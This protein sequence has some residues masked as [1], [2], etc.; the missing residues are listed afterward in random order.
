MYLIFFIGFLIL[1]A[2]H[3]IKQAPEAM[4]LLNEAQ[5]MSFNGP[6]LSQR[7]S[8][9]MEQELGLPW[10]DWNPEI[11]ETSNFVPPSV[12]IQYLRRYF[13]PLIME[14]AGDQV[15]I[16]DMTLGL[17]SSPPEQGQIYQTVISLKPP[18]LRLPP[19]ILR[20]RIGI[21]S[22]LSTAEAIKTGTT[23]DTV[24][25][26]E[27]FAPHRVR[28][29]FQSKLGTE[30][31][32]PF[33][34]DHKWTVEWSDDRLTVYER[35]KLIAPH[36]IAEVALAASEFFDLLKSG[37]DAVDREMKKFIDSAVG[38]AR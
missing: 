5:N 8:S 19:F 17:L 23:L 10:K 1:M 20:P 28:A 3:A 13:G 31:L 27:S 34:M 26:V 37:P 30:V 9:E 24:Y 29:L 33:L 32:I 7:R 4:K 6:A 36:R 16:Y 11:D 25:N 2:R 14:V 12:A 18:E 21:A 15:L 38:S 35:G 22:H